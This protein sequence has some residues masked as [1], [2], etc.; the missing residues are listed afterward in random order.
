MLS[1]PG[2]TLVDNAASFGMS[3][4]VRTAAM[5]DAEQLFQAQ[6][7]PSSISE[8][9]RALNGT[10]GDFERFGQ[11]ISNTT[12][13]HTLISLAEK[14]LTA[15]N[16]L[17]VVSNLNLAEGLALKGLEPRFMNVLFDEGHSDEAT[18]SPQIAATL[19]P[20]APENA[21]FTNLAEDLSS[22]GYQVSSNRGLLTDSLLSRY[23]VLIICSP[24][25]PFAPSEVSSILRFVRNGGGLFF[26]AADWS[27]EPGNDVTTSFGIRI[28]N[29][30]ITTQPGTG[31]LLA[32]DF[33]VT[34]ITQ[35]NPITKGVGPLY[36]NIAAPMQV[37]NGS[38]ADV[39]AWTDRDTY[40]TNTPNSS[41]SP[42]VQGPFPYLISEQYG[43]GRVII[44]ADNFFENPIYTIPS[45]VT[46]AHNTLFWLDN[47]LNRTL[48]VDALSHTIA[49]VDVGSAQDVAFHLVSA[50]TGLPSA[51]ATVTANGTSARANSSGWAT[52]AF[53]SSKPGS[54]TVSSLEASDS[55]GTLR[56]LYAVPPAGVTLVWDRIDII[57]SGNSPCTVGSNATITWTGYYEYDHTPFTGKL[58]LND[59]TTKDTPGTYAYTVS[60]IADQKYGLT[61][62]TSNSVSITFVQQETS[63]TS[64][65]TTSITSLSTTSSSTNTS[66][67]SN[68]L[69][70]LPSYLP[71]VAVLAILAVVTVALVFSRRRRKQS[72]LR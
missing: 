68:I 10:V 3:E 47:S 8:A 19:S 36:A 46:L 29:D 58:T 24:T 42:T 35:N 26:M 64:T 71:A 23:Q 13:Y 57:L 65:S 14:N 72:S 12:E 49:R 20:S 69:E 54:L 45:S 53:T 16:Y 52:L 50:G 11:L 27:P 48:L 9:L 31:N 51:G 44:F 4:G 21:L 63:T 6:S 34:N 70:G 33:L 60:S 41:P 66:S 18:L 32:A 2:K 56:V 17:A 67:L 5:T 61:V 30:Y 28:I 25:K 40:S 37:L 22:L 62:F 15:S 39:L 59:T 55:N 1:Y 43:S 7:Y 38:E